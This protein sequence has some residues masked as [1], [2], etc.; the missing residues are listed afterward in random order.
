MDDA[1]AAIQPPSPKPNPF[2]LPSKEPQPVPTQL[3]LHAAL[4]VAAIS[5]AFPSAHQSLH[6]SIYFW[7]M[8]FSGDYFQD[9]GYRIAGGYAACAAALAYYWIWYVHAGSV[10][11][12]NK[13]SLL[14][15]NFTDKLPAVMRAELRLPEYARLI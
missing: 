3:I 11:V 7:F 14:R 10:G 4:L 2:S 5:R 13:P 12:N 6:L 8:E 15:R 1:N 9:T